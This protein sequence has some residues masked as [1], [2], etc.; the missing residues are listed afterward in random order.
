M[1]AWLFDSPEQVYKGF[2]MGLSKALSTV[3]TAP[4]E[5]RGKTHLVSFTTMGAE[6][7]QDK[8]LVKKKKK[9][10]TCNLEV[11]QNNYYS[12]GVQYFTS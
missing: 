12:R 5:V 2:K 3:L 6:L 11:T 10:P 7:G 1:N 4:T 8:V 9:N